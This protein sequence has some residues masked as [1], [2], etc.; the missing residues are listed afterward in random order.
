MGYIHPVVSEV[1][2]LQSL[3]LIWDKFDKF[4]AREQAHMG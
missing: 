1:Y 2:D 3:D 4:L